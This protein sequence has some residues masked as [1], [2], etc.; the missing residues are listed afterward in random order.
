MT[1]L[2]AILVLTWSPV[3]ET[4]QAN[5]IFAQSEAKLKAARSISGAY[6]GTGRKWREEFLMEKPGSFR[7]ISDSIEIYC[8]GKTQWNHLLDTKEYF[9]RDVSKS[10]GSGTP[11]ALDGFFGR[12]T[13]AS[14]PY[15][16]KR[17]TFDMRRASGKVYAAKTTYFKSFER[18]DHMTYLVD[19]KDKLPI[20]WDQ[21]FGFGLMS[22]RFENL[23]FNVKV[24]AGAFEWKPLPGL[25]EKKVGRQSGR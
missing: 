14:A 16:L 18:N 15:Y 10:G 7:V 25:K 17:T 12:S 23:R 4:E 2:S 5:K 19:A 13:G 1:L 21:D 3:D 11:S 24:A 6:V 20:G 22:F 8:D 9:R